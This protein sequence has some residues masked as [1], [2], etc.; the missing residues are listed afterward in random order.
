MQKRKRNKKAAEQ[1]QISAAERTEAHSILT[2]SQKVKK[3]DARLGT[4]QG[5]DKERKRLA[6][7]QTKAATPAAPKAIPAPEKA[8]E[9]KAGAKKAGKKAGGKKARKAAAQEE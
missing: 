7:L 1:R 6:A 5:A 2:P 4:G 9:P 8:Q 3:L